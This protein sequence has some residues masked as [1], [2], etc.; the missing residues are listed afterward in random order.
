MAGPSQCVKAKA[1]LALTVGKGMET[2]PS[3]IPRAHLYAF[4]YF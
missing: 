2:K 3:H 1:C 4:L